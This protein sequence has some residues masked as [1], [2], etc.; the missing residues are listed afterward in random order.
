[1]PRYVID[2]NLYVRATR[3]NDW[4]QALEGFVL[5][6]TAELFLHSVVALELLAGARTPT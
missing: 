2:T 5:A 6:F 4:N 3:D 1:M